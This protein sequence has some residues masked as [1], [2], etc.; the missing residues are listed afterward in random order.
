MMTTAVQIFANAAPPL[1][2]KVTLIEQIG[3]GNAT[4]RTETIPNG[5]SRTFYV[6]DTMS[7]GIAESTDA[8]EPDEHIGSVDGE[9]Y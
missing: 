1:K 3:D 8:E 6:Y 2:C 5:E 7:I 4:S 9:G